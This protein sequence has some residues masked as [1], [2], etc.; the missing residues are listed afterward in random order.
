MFPPRDLLASER[1]ARR[2]LT[3]GAQEQN[4]VALL[5]CDRSPAA[6]YDGWPFRS[7][8]ADLPQT[9]Q[10]CIHPPS[11]DKGLGSRERFAL[12]CP[13]TLREP[14][15]RPAPLCFPGLPQDG[16]R[17]VPKMCSNTALAPGK[18]VALWPP[19]SSA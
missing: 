2:L 15:R 11:S 13:R 9:R 12:R 3:L 10:P 7:Q 17:L 6:R 18:G 14:A 16:G 4:P 19:R 8:R 1:R 5:G